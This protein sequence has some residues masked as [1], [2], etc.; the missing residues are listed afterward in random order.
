MQS[1]VLIISVQKLVRL[2]DA[3][4]VSHQQLHL[5]IY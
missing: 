1:V 3:A 4:M 2:A 5:T